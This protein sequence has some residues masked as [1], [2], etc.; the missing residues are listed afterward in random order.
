MKDSGY[1]IHTAGL[2]TKYKGQGADIGTQFHSVIY[3]HDE[4]Q[5]ISAQRI[6]LSRQEEKVVHSPGETEITAAPFLI[7]WNTSVRNIIARIDNNGPAK[8]FLTYN[9][10]D[11]EYAKSC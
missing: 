4:A 2:A 3:Y 9:S 1:F 6:L 7:R 11:Q 8:S 5:K 10:K